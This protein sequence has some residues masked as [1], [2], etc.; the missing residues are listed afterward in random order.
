MGELGTSLSPQTSISANLRIKKFEARNPKQIQN[1]NVQNSKQ[2]LLRLK[3]W[4]Q[5]LF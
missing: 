2:Y 1:S 4:L 3:E 5:S